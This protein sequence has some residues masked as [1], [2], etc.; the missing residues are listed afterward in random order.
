MTV[1]EILLEIR[2]LDSTEATLTVC[3][4]LDIAAKKSGMTSP[5]FLK[6]IEPMVT[7]VYRQMGHDGV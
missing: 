6:M 2:E 4:A 5:D 7:E 1:G 3:M